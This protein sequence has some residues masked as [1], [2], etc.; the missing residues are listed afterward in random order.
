[1]SRQVFRLKDNLYLFGEI[2]R[3]NANKF[4]RLLL[5]KDPPKKIVL[6]SEGGYIAEALKICE[7]IRFLPG[8]DIRVQGQAC[9]AATYIL[10]SATGK[11]EITKHSYLMYHL[12]YSEE[13]SVKNSLTYRNQLKDIDFLEGVTRKLLHDN[14]FKTLKSKDF[15]QKF[16]SN[17]EDF[18]LTA[19][20]ALDLGLVDK[21]V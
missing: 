5:S 14:S 17:N 1:M 7:A 16:S 19:K 18:Y 8:I 11:R 6:S 13:S 15:Y 20:E 2:N 21:V 9:S 12:P 10:A 4:V 3:K